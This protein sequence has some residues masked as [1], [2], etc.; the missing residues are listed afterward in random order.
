MNH[1]VSFRFLW[2]GQTFANLGD[3]LYIVG[4]ISLMYQLTG[5]AV[6]MTL[7]PF[8][9]TM[10]Q[11]LSGLL[12][13]LIIDRFRLRSILAFSQLGK[14]CLSFILGWLLFSSF[15]FQ[16]ITFV[17]LLVFMI[18]FLDGWSTP[19]RNSMVPLLVQQIDLVKAN[20]FLSILDQTIRLGAW[21]VGGILVVWLGTYQVIYVTVVCYFASS[22]MMFMIKETHLNSHSEETNQTSL[23][24]T[25]WVKIKE[26]WVFIWKTP[27]V[28]T[29]TIMSVMESLASAVWVAAIIYIY[30]EEVLNVGE[31]WWGYINASF[32]LGLIIG[33]F[34]SLRYNRLINEHLSHVI[35]FGTLISSVFTFLFVV[36]SI[37]WLILILSILIGFGEQL[38]GIAQ[39]TTIQKS[40]PHKEL[41]K[42]YSAQYALQLV[43]YAFSVLLLG[44]LTELLGV[45]ASF[46]LAS[47][48]LF[49]S[50]VF[51]FLNRKQLNQ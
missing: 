12:A 51:S 2:I 31:E 9:I 15:S 32:F 4:L 21:S 34:I 46:L 28:R 42:V 13:P 3:V 19:V 16:N 37:P 35:V 17:F 29:V 7:V 22:V 44:Y 45:N 49:T 41:P 25:N 50:F 6:Y 11:F 36:N 1:S 39:Q 30:V 20:S 27:A 26:G 14:T 33:G 38:G 24:K 5:S 48:L 10:S 23:P 43:T 18:S 47:F 8:F 40:S